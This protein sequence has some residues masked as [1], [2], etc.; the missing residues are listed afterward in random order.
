[1]KKHVVKNSRFPV[2]LVASF[3]LFILAGFLYSKPFKIPKE[4]KA[5]VGTLDINAVTGTAWT[6]GGIWNSSGNVGI[7]TTAPASKLH[8]YD[9]S[10]NNYLTI[11]AP[12]A[13]QSSISFGDITN[14]QDSVLYRPGSTRDLRIYT[15]TA[16]DVV[17]V[18]QAGNVGIGTTAPG[19]RLDVAGNINASGTYYYGDSKA[20]FQYSDT[21]LRLNPTGAFTNGIYAGT[22][23]FRTDG[24]LQVGAS[25]AT[26]GVASGGD[27]NYHAGQIFGDYSTGNVGIGTTAPGYKLEVNGSGK[28]STLYVSPATQT[29]QSVVNIYNTGGFFYI[30]RESS[31][32]GSVLTG[33]SAYAAI[34]SPM[35]TYSMQFGVNNAVAMTIL[36]G[37]N[38]GIGTTAP[39]NK[40]QVAGTIYT[41][42]TVTAASDIRH[43]T[44]IQTLPKNTLEK[45]LDLRGVSFNW[46]TEY[47][48][49]YPDISKANQIGVIAQEVEKIYPELVLT[50]PDGYKSVAY[51]RFGPILIEAVKEQ[52]KEI[53]SLKSEV[54]SLKKDIEVIKQTLKTNTQ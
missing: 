6:P 13:A 33:S 40:L 36:N 4:V 7:G 41:S 2:V 9:A 18:T 21:W 44:N 37:G 47:L 53:D 43:K 22:T 15:T 52:Q 49:K 25:G 54:D 34:L 27:L 16:G 11:T 14:G 8:L 38:V 51:D 30:G 12:L 32:G 29:N 31:S 19:D 35:G 48:K 46:N 20:M 24:T 50:D 1:M 26:L 17:S 5:V 23:I 28:I 3:F 42:S 45:V 10:V 39:T